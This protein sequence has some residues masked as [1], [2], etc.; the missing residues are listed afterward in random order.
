MPEIKFCREC[1]WSVLKDSQ[2]DF[3]CCNPKVNKNDPYALTSSA[4]FAGTNC[5]IERG[6]KW[7]AV[8]GIKG[9]QWEPKECQ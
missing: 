2:F 3:R 5:T 1:K 8:C 6:V 7:F 9:K 4:Q